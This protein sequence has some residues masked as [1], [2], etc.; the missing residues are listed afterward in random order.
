MTIRRETTELSIEYKKR[1]GT[2]EAESTYAFPSANLVFR[3]TGQRGSPRPSYLVRQ[4]F[5]T[6]SEDS[7]YSGVTVH[8]RRDASLRVAPQS[9]LRKLSACL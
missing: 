7:A 6:T 4:W 3:Y 2:A 5:G 1:I 8:S 9:G